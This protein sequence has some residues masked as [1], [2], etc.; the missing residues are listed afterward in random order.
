MIAAAARSVSP[1]ASSR[2]A[3]LMGAAVV[4]ASVPPATPATLA[5]AAFNSARG[6]SAV[7]MAAGAVVE[8]AHQGL[9]AMKTASANRSL[10]VC[11]R[12]GYPSV[13]DA[14]VRTVSAKG[15]CTA[16]TSSG[17]GPAWIFAKRSAEAVVR[18]NVSPRAK[19]KSAALTVAGATAVCAPRGP[20]APR[21]RSAASP[22][23]VPSA[24]VMTVAAMTVASVPKERYVRISN[25]WP[26]S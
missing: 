24:T 5:S 15:I 14:N 26:S 7:R 20:F 8:N 10:D 6:S 16:V 1:R 9:C 25:A 12:L 23:A 3:A 11:Q 21:W 2:S 4:A 17:T 13:T 18:W 19:A 22:N